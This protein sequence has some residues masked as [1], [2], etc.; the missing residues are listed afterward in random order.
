MTAT[1]TA[2]VTAIGHGDVDLF[3]TACSARNHRAPMAS[4]P[5]SEGK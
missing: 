5:W 4:D 2:T 3:R 1:A